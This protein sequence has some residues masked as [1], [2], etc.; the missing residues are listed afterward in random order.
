LFQDSLQQLKSLQSKHAVVEFEVNNSAL[1]VDATKG[2]FNV[3]TINGSKLKID[4]ESKERTAELNALLVKAG[5][6]VS[7]VQLQN[8]DLEKMFVEITTAK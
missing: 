7:Q 5:V 4:F 1:A 8:H 3:Q 6:Q 2:I